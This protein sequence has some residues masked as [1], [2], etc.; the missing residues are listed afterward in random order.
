MRQ[1]DQLN[2][3]Q[4]TADELKIKIDQ[5]DQDINKLKSD[6]GHDRQVSVLIEY[7][8]Y[9]LDELKRKQNERQ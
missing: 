2:N 8:D 3:H 4:I 6:G 1:V 7:K 9:L 5:L